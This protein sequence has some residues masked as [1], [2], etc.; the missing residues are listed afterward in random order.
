VKR[1]TAVAAALAAALIAC[2]ASVT[3]EAQCSMCR[4]L[5]ATPEGERIAAALRS[6]IWLLLAAPFA[7]FAIVAGAAMKSRRRFEATNQA[8]PPPEHHSHTP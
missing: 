3:L 1:R 6:G 4:T 7:V 2:A 5:L 8:A